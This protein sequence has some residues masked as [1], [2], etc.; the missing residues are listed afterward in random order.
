MNQLSRLSPFAR[1]AIAALLTLSVNAMAADPYPSR[2]ITLPMGFTPGGGADT[3]ADK[4]GKLLGQPIIIDNRPGA[5][6]TLAST[7]VARA[8]PDGYA[9]IGTQAA[10]LQRSRTLKGDRVDIAMLDC[11]VALLE[12]AIA[13]L[14]V[15]GKAPGPLGS[16]HPSII[17]F[18][19]FRAADSSF[20]IAASNNILFQRLCN[21]LELTALIDDAR[22]LTN[23]LRCLNH[24]ALKDLLE[25]RLG[26]QSSAFWQE[27]LEANNIPTESYND[28]AAVMKDPQVHAREMLVEMQASGGG[29]LKVAGNPVRVGSHRTPLVHQPPRLDQDRTAILESL[30]SAASAKMAP[31]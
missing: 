6:T 28:L 2:P 21:L 7:Y 16:R 12:N 10:L 24:A 20:V 19:V 3:V 22:F 8:A 18:D 31:M 23:E 17:P 11:Q 13:R 1:L 15:D 26:S 9:A 4:M 29:L 5:G 25:E 14:Q 27:L 30:H